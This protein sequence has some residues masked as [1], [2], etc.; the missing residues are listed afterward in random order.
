MHDYNNT[1][2]WTVNS[3]NGN[4]KGQLGTTLGDVSFTCADFAWEVADC[5]RSDY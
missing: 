4:N 2:F 3:Q 1:L 5:N